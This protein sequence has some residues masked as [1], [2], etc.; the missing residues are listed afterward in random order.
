MENKPHKEE[1]MEGKVILA[2]DFGT[3]GNK[4]SLYD[5]DGQL[6][7]S[8]YRPY[9]TLYPQPTW[10]EQNPD[11][12]WNALILSTKEVLEA[13]KTPPSQVLGLS[14]S[15]QMMAG[16]PVD[17]QGNVLQNSVMIWADHRS[18]S[19]AQFI[20]EKFGWHPFYHLTGSGMEI[21]LY[22]VAKILWLKN[23]LPE[24]YN[25]TYKFL[26]AK[27]ILIQRLTGRFA[28]D[29]SDASNTGL[30]DIHNK[31][32][33][34]E[35][36]MEV[37][38][39]RNKLPDEILPAH[40]MVGKVNKQAAD[41]LGLLEGTPVILGGG[42]V[43]CA[44]L[45]AG[46]I[47]EGSAYN[48]IGSASWL[49]VASPKPIFD[50]QMRPFTLCHVVPERYVVQLA[51]FSAGVAFEWFRDHIC[52]M[53]KSYAQHRGLDAYDLMTQ[54]AAT[55]TPGANGLIFLPNL[56]P[57][58]APHNNLTDHGALVGLTLTHKREDILRSVIEGITFNIRLM[59]E[60]MERQLGVIFPEIR[61]IGGGSKSE[62]W[63][64]IE[65]NILNKKIVTLSAH[66]E[67][68]SLGATIIA[69][70]ALGVFQ[71]FDEGVHKFVKER[72]VVAPKPE[73]VQVYDKQFPFFNQS[74]A[75]LCQVNEGLSAMSSS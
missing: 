34:D 37:G 46:I 6:V 38:I 50:E 1:K 32:W 57:G 3:T 2:H 51:M 54:E 45:G 18:A 61:M 56:R 42:D 36:V 4:A 67:A 27:D 8:C 68:N 55:S 43:A 31:K 39:D 13:S 14:F 58:G 40:T 73:D 23:N 20:K 70:V 48:Y 29:Y 65:A 19:E 26:G 60:A 9:G 59:C 33:A 66:Q 72:E 64:N 10:V 41:E 44:A 17:R 12:W 47:H 49:A 62:L 15:G 22:P 5:L 52:W 21:P 69:G 28:T 71:D 30:L 35:L 25:S 53:E 11:E 16:I 75:A 63:R 24:I 74:Y 7:K